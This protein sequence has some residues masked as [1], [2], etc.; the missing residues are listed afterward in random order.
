MKK[1]FLIVLFLIAGNFLFAG[2]EQEP[3]PAPPSFS[4]PAPPPLPPQPPAPP[5]PDRSRETPVNKSESVSQEP[6]NA[7]TA[8]AKGIAA[9]NQGKEVTA[10]YYYFLAAA[11][12]PSLKEAADR[13]S[14]LASYIK[15]GAISNSSNSQNAQN[16]IQWR[17]EWIARLTET[18]QLYEDVCNNPT[19]P[20]ILFYQTQLKE[21]G[22]D[23]KDETISIGT[24]VVLCVSNVWIN[25]LNQ[26]LKCVYLGLEA[27]ERATLYWEIRGWP[28]Q[29]VTNSNV[30]YNLTQRIQRTDFEIT[31][32]LVNNRNKVLGSHT[33]NLD[34]RFKAQG[35]N[36]TLI[37][38]TFYSYGYTTYNFWFGGINLSDLT[39][40]MTLH[41]TKINGIDTQIAVRNGLLQIRTLS[42]DPDKTDLKDALEEALDTDADKW[43]INHGEAKVNFYNEL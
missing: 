16:D 10:L 14:Q 27:T 38:V 22:I 5:P 12:D 24:F 13:S 1:L 37:P 19:W 3:P 40:K 7:Q 28:L 32:E 20:H 43:E 33:F 9:Q 8:L 31:I 36:Y 29:S 39:D 34:T 35:S 6:I 11:L 18:E 42:F 25:T 21:G 17:K 2:G 26:L 23:Y 4:P 15:N 30:F 41:I